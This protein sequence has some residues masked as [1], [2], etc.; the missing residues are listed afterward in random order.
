MINHHCFDISF[1]TLSI[2]RTDNKKKMSSKYFF[3]L[4]YLLNFIMSDT[5]KR[6]TGRM[7]I[8]SGRPDPQWTMTND[9]WNE[10]NKLIETLSGKVEYQGIFDEPSM[11]G[12]RGFVSNWKDEQ[13]YYIALEKQAVKVKTNLFIVYNDPS[14]SVEIWFLNNAK[15]NGNLDL[16]IPEN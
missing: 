14:K 15:K 7:M 12:Y 3:C 9:D 2:G 13:I 11:L 10:L 6:P 1:V 16:Q 5:N 4:I 8:Y